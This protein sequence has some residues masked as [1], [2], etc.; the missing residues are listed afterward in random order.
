MAFANAIACLIWDPSLS[1]NAKI[2]KLN[3]RGQFHARF[4]DNDI[5]L[6]FGSYME[7]NKHKCNQYYPS[8]EFDI[9]FIKLIDWYNQI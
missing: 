6:L 3:L 4:I 9:N 7:S 8:S 1:S 5:H 2:L